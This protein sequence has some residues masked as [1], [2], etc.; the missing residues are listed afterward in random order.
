MFLYHYYDA[1][2]KPFQNL[3]DI[4]ID[5]AKKILMD[6]ALKKPNTQCAKRADEY[7]ELRHHYED[8]LRCEFVKKGGNIQREAPH[9]MVVEHSPWLASWFENSAFIK[10]SIEEFDKSTISFTYGDS[11]PTFSPKVNDGKEYRKKLY[12]YDEILGIIAKY[13]YPQD[14]NNDGK[15]G[16]ER[17]IEA[18]IWSDDVIRKFTNRA[19]N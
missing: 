19:L 8:I 17:Y 18:H 2:M 16:P 11:H 5:E 6:I 13:G 12:T 3:S 7:M 15:Y 4:P 14:W 1:S 10:I 9:Y